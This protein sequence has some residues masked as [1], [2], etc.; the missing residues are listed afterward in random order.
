M[1]LGFQASRCSCSHPSGVAEIVA[2][3]SRIHGEGGVVELVGGSDGEL[4]G[5]DRM[6]GG[7]DGGVGGGKGVEEHDHAAQVGWVAIFA[8]AYPRGQLRA[9][10]SGVGAVGAD[11]PDLH[12]GRDRHELDRHDEGLAFFYRR[13]R[14]PVRGEGREGRGT[15]GAGDQRRGR[16]D[17]PGALVAGLGG[18][19]P[20]AG[21]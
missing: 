3:C 4:D 17:R 19:A 14:R 8:E 11:R 5:R 20:W 16:Q 21:S 6:R 18:D 15:G 12:E 7:E 9:L 13:G 10:A 2:A 1:P